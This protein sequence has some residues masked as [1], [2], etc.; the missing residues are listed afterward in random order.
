MDK[1]YKPY[2]GK[3]P[4]KF[5]NTN[6]NTNTMPVFDSVGIGSVN[7]EEKTFQ[8]IL[9]GIVCTSNINQFTTD[10]KNFL[11]TYVSP[12]Y[13]TDPCIYS[14]NKEFMYHK[15][16]NEDRIK[17]FALL[18]SFLTSTQYQFVL[19]D[20]VFYRI[21]L[22]SKDPSDNT[23]KLFWTSISMKVYRRLVLGFPLCVFM[24]QNLVR[25]FSQTQIAEGANLYFL[26][27][28]VR[29]ATSLLEGIME[30]D[31]MDIIFQKLLI[32]YE[33]YKYGLTSTN[34]IFEEIRL[35]KRT[36]FAFKIKDMVF[37]FSCSKIIIL[38]PITNLVELNEPPINYV[39]SLNDVEKALLKQ[40][41]CDSFMELFLVNFHSTFYKEMYNTRTL[42]TIYQLSEET[43]HLV[44]GKSYILSRKETNAIFYGIVLSVSETH[45]KTLILFDSTIP[46]S[47]TTK[48]EVQR[49]NNLKDKFLNHDL[50]FEKSIFEYCIGE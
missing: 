49:R 22:N 27:H 5:I 35:D 44:P 18:N 12:N 21:F 48:I 14:A 10:F 45:V 36:S 39:N 31:I 7:E 29:Q 8:K 9:Q 19:S 1:Q 26:K 42:Y 50:I 47:N 32:F 16:A 20:K 23:I 3:K 37:V 15:N 33:L 43:N 41:D 4:N 40:P 46:R 17:R 24:N 30:N 2:Q 28:D 38:C 34:Y 11:S 13:N 6:T 25:P